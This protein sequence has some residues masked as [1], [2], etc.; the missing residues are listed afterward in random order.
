M[1]EQADMY[2]EQNLILNNEI[3]GIELEKNWA[4]QL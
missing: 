2:S 4:F 1:E 3:A